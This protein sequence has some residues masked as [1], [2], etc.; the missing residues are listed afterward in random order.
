MKRLI[1]DPKRKQS[2]KGSADAADWETQ[3]RSPQGLR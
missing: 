2:P 3:G 1:A